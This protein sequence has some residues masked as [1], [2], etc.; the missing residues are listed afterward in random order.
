MTRFG[1]VTMGLAVAIIWS[2]GAAQA[3]TTSDKWS[4]QVDAAATMGHSSSSSVGG[5]VDYRWKSNWDLAIELG[6]MSNITTQAVQ[7]RGTAIATAIGAIANA[8]AA[9]TVVQS[10]IY[11]DL[12]AR[13]HL[14]P[15][16][17]WNPYVAVGFGGARVNT[18][19]T[20][21]VSGAQVPNFEGIFGVQLGND[22]DGYVSKAFLMAGFGVTRPVKKKYLLDASYRFGRVF[23]SGSVGGDT[24]VNTQRIQI[25]LGV[26]F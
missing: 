12:A 18:Q 1:Q 2:A 21:T 20:F 25:G 16:G 22:L 4:V 17:T 19:T 11:Y 6:H 13:Y 5:E 10:A 3:Q 23:P 14:M 8:P 26:R 9:A 15:D 24:G 7:D